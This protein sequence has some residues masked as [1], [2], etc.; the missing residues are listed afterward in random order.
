MV[1]SKKNIKKTELNS[2][3]HATIFVVVDEFGRRLPRA[4]V[5]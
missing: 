1:I 3:M 4:R 5:W 2:G